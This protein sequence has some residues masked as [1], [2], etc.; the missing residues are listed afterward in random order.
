MMQM[1]THVTI[2]TRYFRQSS[3]SEVGDD[4]IARLLPVVVDG[5]GA[6]FR[7]F[8]VTIL[9]RD[10]TAAIYDIEWMDTPFVR[11]WL[12]M[13]RSASDEVWDLA[14]ADTAHPPVPTD[15]PLP[16]LATRFGHLTE[17]M[18]H[19]DLRSIWTQIADLERCLAWTI[20]E[21][22]ARERDSAS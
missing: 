21:L 19:D 5:G 11:C 13:D 2:D 3:R 8:D 14:T 17:T 7:E 22:T 20:I 4:I 15:M 9:R 12:C 1:L 10:A 6:F 18:V 16:W